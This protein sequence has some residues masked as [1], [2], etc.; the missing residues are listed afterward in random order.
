[1]IRPRW[2]KILRDIW[3]KKT[4]TVLVILS[5]AV[6][7]F[8]VGAVA[9]M[10]VIVT[11]DMV[12]SYEA[13]NPPSAI[14][15]TDKPFSDRMVEVIRRMPG[16]AAAEAR[17]E[18]VLRFQHP[19]SD[20]WYPLRLYAVPDYEHMRIST[21]QRE[22]AF[23]PDPERW[24]NPG[25]FPPPDRQVLLERTSAL[26]TS[27]GIAPDARQGDALLVETPAGKLRK[28]PMAGMVYDSVHGAAPWTGT[29]YGYVT[30]DTME[31]LGLPRSYNELHVLVSGDRHDTAHI[32]AVANTIERR[33]NNSGIEVTRLRIPTPG[34]L[35]QDGIFQALVLLLSALGVGSLVLSVFLLINTV[36][37]LLTQ[38]V[39]QI[40]VMKAVGGRTGQIMRLY[41]GMVILFGL[42]ALI[43]AV[44][45]SAYAALWIINFLSYLVNFNLGEFS[46]PPQVVLFEA[47]VAIGVPLLAGLVPILS[48]TRVTV[49]EAIASYGLAASFG[50]GRLDRLLQSVR[51]LPAAVAM[52]LRNTFR[53]KG[54]LILTLV[55][56]SLAGTIFM[57]VVNVRASALGTV[58]EILQY[59]QFDVTADLSQPYRISRLEPLATSI[60]GVAAVEAW[61]TGTTFRVRPDGTESKAIF[62]QGAP[63][64]S[65]MIQPTVLQGRWLEPP[66]DNAVVVTAMLL[67]DE[68]DLA[69][70]KDV[71]LELN[72]DD[73]TWNIVGVV[74]F[75]QPVAIAFVNYD[76]LARH[77][78]TA[79]KATAL[80]IATTG[81]TPAA[82][83]AVASALEARLIDAG[84]KVSS[85]R[86]I[87]QI[88]DSV[89]VLFNIIITFLMSMAVVL[90][91]V[92]GIGLAGT[93][94]LNVLERIRE[95]GVLRAIGA[96]NAAVLQVVIIEGVFIGL[97][98]WVIAVLLSIPIGQPI[99]AG[100]G[101]ATLN[102]PLSYTVSTTGMLLWLGLVVGIAIVASYFPARQAAGLSVREVLAYEQ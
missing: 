17:R 78:G 53:S 82:R 84:L 95:V 96:G 79:G 61:G 16:V 67:A 93:M 59:W 51:G 36:S 87:E 19:Q 72:G 9:H 35:P 65:Q 27:Q 34:K 98:S 38:Q 69:V 60:S 37:A 28:L 90:A 26:L 49:R 14:L 44:P 21:L 2:R 13:A 29:A 86:T 10:R 50:T 66:D 91:I 18:I 76:A 39:R 77:N 64:G 41:L 81:H 32:E 68:P 45:V 73:T 57:A 92:G 100:V 89:E 99:A 23:G 4:R 58:D 63:A 46:I 30:L 6:G 20:A 74:R 97:L 24:P 5:I 101:M 52:S 12:Q 22:L 33:F 54:R 48:G 47:A 11:D 70:G 85:V 31:W 75:A 42:A 25:V 8:A 56:L 1:M 71:V 94:S 7:V 15:T 43:I 83:A 3:G 62:I 55:T 88:R 40:G 80:N 102:A